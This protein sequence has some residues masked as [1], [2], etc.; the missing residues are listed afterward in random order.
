MNW[1]RQRKRKPR[2]DQNPAQVLLQAAAVD[3][4]AR[5]PRAATH[6]TL[7]AIHLQVPAHPNNFKQT[8]PEKTLINAD[9]L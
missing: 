8:I 2:K 6:Q 5:R 4:A 3:P 9:F 1:S 7:K